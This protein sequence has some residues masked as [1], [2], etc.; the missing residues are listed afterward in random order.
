MRGNAWLAAGLVAAALSG[1][2]GAAGC[3]AVI[4]LE[5]VPPVLDASTDARRGPDASDA[6][7]AS[8]GP[9]VCVFDDPT[10]TFDT[11]IFQ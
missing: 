8:D 5:D 2:L 11:C 4:G 9:P 3:Q 1:L 10:T 7:D 6:G